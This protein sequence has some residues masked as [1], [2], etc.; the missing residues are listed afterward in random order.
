M[1]PLSEWVTD[2]AARAEEA[3]TRP[4]RYRSKTVPRCRSAVNSSRPQ[5]ITKSH[6]LAAR[7][8]NWSR[9]G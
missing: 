5:S 4:L 7:P 2:L 3:G 8:T 6:W 1:K 9:G